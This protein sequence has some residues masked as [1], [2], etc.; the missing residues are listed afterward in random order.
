MQG[1]LRFCSLSGAAALVTT[2]MTTISTSFAE[3]KTTDPFGCVLTVCQSKSHMLQEAMKAHG[4]RGAS[5]VGHEATITEAMP[6]SKIRN[7]CPVDKD[8]LG[9]NTWTMLHTLSAYFPDEPTVEQ[10]S[11]ASVLLLTLSKLYPCS[12]CAADFEI[13]VAEK[14]PDTTS[15]EALSLWMCRL[16][17]SVNQKLGKPLTPCKISTL[18]ERWRYGSPG[19]QASMSEENYKE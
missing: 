18:D 4:T 16:H 19:C 17:N 14:P 3:G 1:C 7:E 2:T 12:I 10:Q 9:F 8:E 11:Y 15:R 6:N 5:R 13:Y